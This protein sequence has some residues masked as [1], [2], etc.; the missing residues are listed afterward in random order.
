MLARAVDRATQYNLAIS[1]RF[2][3]SKNN[4]NNQ[5]ILRVNLSLNKHTISAID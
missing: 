1:L 4:Q 3:S 2:A 5:F